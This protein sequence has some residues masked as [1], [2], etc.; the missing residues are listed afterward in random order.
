MRVTSKDRPG[1][2]K[3][4]SG[5]V[6]AYGMQSS[7]LIE[8]DS[9]G[10]R[11]T[12]AIRTRWTL[13]ADH[14]HGEGLGHAR[15]GRG[16]HPVRTMRERERQES[17]RA[18]RSRGTRR[19]RLRLHESRPERVQGVPARKG[20]RRDARSPVRHVPTGTRNR[21]G[22]RTP[23]TGQE[24]NNGA[25][26][27]EHRLS[28]RPSHIRVPTCSPLKGWGTGG[29]SE[30]CSGNNAGTGGNRELRLSSGSQIPPKLGSQIPQILPNPPHAKDA[31]HRPKRGGGSQLGTERS[32]RHPVNLA[33]I[34]SFQTFSEFPV[35]GNYRGNRDDT[36]GTGR[37]QV[38]EWPLMTERS[39]STRDAPEPVQVIRGAAVRST[40]LT[41]K[42]GTWP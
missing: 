2:I 14:A 12:F 18:R 32:T 23:G 4:Y 35:P 28:A 11:T 31:R 15:S 5:P 22:S 16:T 27:R 41:R 24:R 37:E 26:L 34:A 13:P 36:P 20:I 40:T 8:F 38:G 39:R 1:G 25:K 10:E 9:D 21:T 6:G 3:P 17:L 30:P 7:A 29:R 33:R 19:G 42:P